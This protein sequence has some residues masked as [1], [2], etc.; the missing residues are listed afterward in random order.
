MVDKRNIQWR[1][2]GIYNSRE[3][4]YTIADI[5]NKQ[6]QIDRAKLDSCFLNW[7]MITNMH[8]FNN[9]L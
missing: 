1:R 2:N 3:M 5:W 8:E 7:K 6:W 9:Q 4:E